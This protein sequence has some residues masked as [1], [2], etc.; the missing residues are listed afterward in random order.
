MLDPDQATRVAPA[1]AGPPFVAIP[2][3]VAVLDAV[4][5]GA[6]A[7]IGGL[8]LDLS[9]GASLALGAC[10]FLLALAGFVVFGVRSIAVYRRNLVV[11]FPTP[12]GGDGIPH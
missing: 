3:V 4:V 9:T 10:S 2:G 8:G 5:A 6:T 11:R 1:H 7:G 12:S